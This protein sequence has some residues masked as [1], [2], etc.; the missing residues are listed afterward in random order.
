MNRRILLTIVLCSVF[1]STAH[2]ATIDVCPACA[3]PSIR[4]AIAHARSGDTIAIQHGTYVEGP[5]V[6]DKPLTLIGRD[7]PVIDGKGEGNVLVIR[8][9]DVTVDGVTITHGGQSYVAEFAG[10]R[11]EDADRCVIRNNI[12]RESTY[13]VYLAKAHACTV[14]NNRIEGHAISEVAGGNGVHLW[15]STQITIRGNTVTGHRDGLYLEFSTDS[16][17]ADNVA[18]D[19]IRYGLHFMYCHRNRYLRNT[20]RANQTGVAV[21][22]SRNIVM[23]GN[24]FE[25]SWGRTSYGLLL[26]DITDG[27]IEDNTFQA[28]TVGIVADAVSRNRFSRNT[29]RNN[30][31]A[32]T[33]LGNADTNV[34]SENDFIDNFFSVATNARTS[35]NQ[36]A[37]NYWSN[38]RGY[39]LDHDG[40]GDVPFRPVAIFSLWVSR[41]PEL[42]ALLDSPAIQFLEVA[43]RVLPVLTPKNLEDARPHMR[44]FGARQ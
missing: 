4:E 27:V 13:G 34:F 31:W 29:F 6:I 24:R 36:F 18:T 40:W 23:T 41:Y 22:Y 3:V 16:L 42:V 5:L 14:E 38:Y 7:Q 12:I 9:D 33:I 39:D 21:M 32:L 35:Q 25:N 30:G 44:P 19:N 37:E 15:Y 17:I 10:I 8:A 11:V 1:S 2:A 28:N 26:K 43:E 20:F